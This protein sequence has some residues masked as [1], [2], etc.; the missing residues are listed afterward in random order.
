MHHLIINSQ[1]HIHYKSSG[2]IGN[3]Q[4]KDKKTEKKK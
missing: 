2:Q 4:M 3:N 1:L